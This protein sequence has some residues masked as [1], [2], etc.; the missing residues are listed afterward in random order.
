MLLCVSAPHFVAG[1]VWERR[2]YAWHCLRAAPILHWML[3]KTPA[4]CGNYFAR[5]GWAFEW[6]PLGE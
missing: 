1:A 4:H 3:G 5:K 2:G 6:I